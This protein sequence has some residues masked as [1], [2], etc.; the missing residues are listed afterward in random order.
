[1]SKT[2]YSGSIALTKLVSVEMT[3]NGQNGQPVKGIFIPYAKNYITEK[4]GAAYLNINVVLHEVPDQY[5]NDGFIS[6]RLDSEK[7][8]ELG[9]EAANAL[10]LPILGNVRNFA[11]GGNSNDSSGKAATIAET[12]DL[13]W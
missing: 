1:M 3:K 6:H 9:K 8:K 11:T 2:N 4:D 10:K 5:K 12:D 13:P 7:Y